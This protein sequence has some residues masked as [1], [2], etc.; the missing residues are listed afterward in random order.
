M[1]CP[2]LHPGTSS[3][4]WAPAPLGSLTL[5]AITDN[6][7]DITDGLADVAGFALE[8]RTRLHAPVNQPV[9]TTRLAG[10]TSGTHALTYYDTDQS[11]TRALFENL[12][13][14]GAVIIARHSTTITAATRL[15][16]W[17]VRIGTLADAYPANA[18]ATFT[19]RFTGNGRP[20]LDRLP[21]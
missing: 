1:I 4:W 3:V 16:Y 17:P 12:H 6:T 19:I 9:A 21:A 13:H 18:P 7:V 8:A 5:A 10:L 20:D 11:A 15:D 2:Y 14:A